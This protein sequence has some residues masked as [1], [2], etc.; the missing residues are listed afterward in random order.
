MTTSTQPL[1][2]SLPVCPVADCRTVGKIPGSSYGGRSYCVG[3][4]GSL[5]PRAK[6]E[7]RTFVEE[8]EILVGGGQDK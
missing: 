1:T 3:K 2:I 8:R 4:K 7:L 5:H 6:M